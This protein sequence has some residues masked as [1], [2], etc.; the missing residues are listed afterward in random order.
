MFLSACKI[1]AWLL[2]V[3]VVLSALFSARSSKVGQLDESGTELQRAARVKRRRPCGIFRYKCA[4]RYV[5]LV[6][7]NSF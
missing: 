3:L 1:V 4:K 5:N 6:F 7:T 2:I